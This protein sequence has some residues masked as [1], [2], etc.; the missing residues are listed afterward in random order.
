MKL[1]LISGLN[2]YKQLFDRTDYTRKESVL[3][4]V[5]IPFV[6]LLHT[7]LFLWI[8]L[9]YLLERLF[10]FVFRFFIGLQSKVMQKRALS[11][12]A[13][14]KVYTLS[15]LII[16]IL[17]L[18]FIIIY[19]VAMLLKYIGKL[20]MKKLLLAFDFSDQIRV[21]SFYIFDDAAFDANVRMSGMMKDLSQ[22]QAIGSAFEQMM[23]G[24]EDD[25][26]NQK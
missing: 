14:K 21:A 4:W 20:W 8:T 11:V 13:F 9:F 22:T 15:S 17:F 6:L 2:T 25:I 12:Q 26:D 19:Y 3:F 5:L 18:P 10:A 16:F 23:R 7:L 24:M 1:V